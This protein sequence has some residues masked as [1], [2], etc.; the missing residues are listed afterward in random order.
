MRSLCLFSS[1]KDS[2][3]PGGRAKAR[4]RGHHQ[5]RQEQKLRGSGQAAGTTGKGAGRTSGG[6][7][8]RLSKKRGSDELI[9]ESSLERWFAMEPER[10]P[11]PADSALYFPPVCGLIS[12]QRKP[13]LA[14][15]EVTEDAL[16][17][18]LRREMCC[19]DGLPHWTVCARNTPAW[20]WTC[21][22]AG[23]SQA[24]GS[25]C[26]RLGDARLPA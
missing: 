13:P 18:R 15:R 4:R 9:V 23:C 8:C 1:W 24:W 14:V 25:V 26:A 6:R 17:G 5:E 12:I 21:A 16:S 7:A 2:D 19:E 3:D 11:D 22:K 20:P 10:S